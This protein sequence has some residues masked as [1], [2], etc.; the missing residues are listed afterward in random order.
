MRTQVA[1]APRLRETHFDSFVDQ[2][3]GLAGWNQLYRQLSPGAFRGHIVA[4]DWGAFTLYRETVNQCM[5]NI[6]RVPDGCAC[7]GF[8]LGKRVKMTGVTQDIGAGSGMI[9]VA[10]EDYHIFTDSQSDYIMLTVPLDKLPHG[11]AT[12]VRS[13]RLNEGHDIA[14]WMLMLLESARKGI[15]QEAVLHLA[16]DLLMDRISL[17]APQDQQATPRR[18]TPRGLIADILDAC[19]TL[20]FDLLSVSALSEYLDRDRA[21]LRSACLERTGLSLDHLLKGRRMSEVHRRLRSAD[22]RTTKVS[23][24]S[25]EY[26][27]FHWGRFAQSYRA[28]FGE[29][30]SDTLRRPADTVVC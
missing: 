19:E 6:Y 24:V 20:P 2:E 13:L 29:R 27:Y 18:K 4:L 7:V 10:D 28:M 14:G 21:T 30:P 15:A 3:R 22:P 9:N 5:E 11:V 23:D 1:T 16:P 26:G 12:G 25:M 8:S 17:W